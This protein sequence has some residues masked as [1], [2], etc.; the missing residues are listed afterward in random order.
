MNTMNVQY[1]NY[2]PTASL[3]VN[4]EFYATQFLAGPKLSFNISKYTSIECIALA[5]YNTLSVP[6]TTFYGVKDTTVYNFPTGT[7][8][9]YKIGAGVKY[10]TLDGVVGLHINLS[11]AGSLISFP[12]YTVYYSAGAV[13][14]TYNVNKTTSLGIIQISCGLSF[15]LLDV[16]Q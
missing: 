5:G 1:S 2:F 6:T 12:N 4:T 10:V 7:G 14:N 3:Y 15:N 13:N 11:Y 16:D 8:F 9:G